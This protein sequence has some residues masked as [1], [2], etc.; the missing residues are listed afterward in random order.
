[1]EAGGSVLVVMVL[2]GGLVPVERGL[3][4]LEGFSGLYSVERAREVQGEV[5]PGD[6][7]GFFVLVPEVV[8]VRGDSVQLL[9]G[10]CA[11]L[12]VVL[13][14]HSGSVPFG[15][16]VLGVVVGVREGLG[17][18]HSVGWDAPGFQV[19]LERV[20]TGEVELPDAVPAVVEE[21]TSRGDAEPELRNLHGLLVHAQPEQDVFVLGEVVG[22][23]KDGCLGV[24]FGIN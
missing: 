16:C 4:E 21:R 22:A 20:C 18:L 3:H 19:L 1:M 24:S 14:E 5:L 12:S 13:H 23:G 8:H 11:E 6:E 15:S 10:D 9:L 7:H 17:G 2:D